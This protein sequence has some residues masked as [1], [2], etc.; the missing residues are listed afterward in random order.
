MLLAEPRIELRTL[1]DGGALPG[2]VH[3]KYLLVEGSFDGDRDARWVFTGSHN[4]NETSLRR[5]DETLL[6][7]NDRRVYRQYV[8]NFK[9]MRAVAPLAPATAS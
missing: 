5:N 8:D 2:R 4:Y 3:S 1:G 6:R 7:L 9:R